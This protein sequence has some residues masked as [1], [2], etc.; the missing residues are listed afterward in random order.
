[1]NC[2]D[3]KALRYTAYVHVECRTYHLTGHAL[4]SE[5]IAGCHG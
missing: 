3:A 5:F 1:M 4:R 2:I